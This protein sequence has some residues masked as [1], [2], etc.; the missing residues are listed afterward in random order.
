[1]SHKCLTQTFELTL[2]ADL[3]PLS[4]S[5]VFKQVFQ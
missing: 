1:M 5:S 4:S 2:K 3:L